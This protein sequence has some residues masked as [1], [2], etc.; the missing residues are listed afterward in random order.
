MR[1]LA[2][3][4]ADP[5]AVRVL[6]GGAFDRSSCH[7]LTTAVR[8]A[9]AVGSD[10]IVVDV[11]HVTSID[12]S[13]IRALLTCR[14]LA[15]AA[16]GSLRVVK[17]SGIVARVLDICDVRR[18]LCPPD[19][20]GPVPVVRPAP[21]PSP[22]SGDSARPFVAEV[23][24]SSAVLRGHAADLV[25]ASREIMNRIAADRAARSVRSMRPDGEG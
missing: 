15:V 3:D 13:T 24:R 17:D 4:P 16:G 20:S 11:E 7:Q 18:L 8:D 1:L 9:L 22:S 14:D 25:V 2:P 21:K 5:R 23:N 19:P 6:A 10:C 12:A